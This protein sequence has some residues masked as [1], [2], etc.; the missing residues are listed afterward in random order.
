MSGYINT[1]RMDRNVPD[2]PEMFALLQQQMKLY[3]SVRNIKV[4]KQLDNIGKGLQIY[5][6]W[7]LDSSKNNTDN[8]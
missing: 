2:L 1:L 3:F 4:D 6:S 8:I 7:S 5:N